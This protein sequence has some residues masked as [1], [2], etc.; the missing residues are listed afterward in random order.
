MDVVPSGKALLKL[1]GII[2]CVQ[3]AGGR[4]PITGGKYVTLIELCKAL[5]AQ[6]PVPL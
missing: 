2:R 6:G 3:R 4:R 1:V 5:S